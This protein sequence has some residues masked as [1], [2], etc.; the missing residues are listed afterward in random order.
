MDR[1]KVE[2]FRTNHDLIDDSVSDQLRIKAILNSN[3]VNEALLNNVEHM[4]GM[5]FE[6][7]QKA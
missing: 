1:R 3:K 6:L 5:E 4:F 7:K 2:T